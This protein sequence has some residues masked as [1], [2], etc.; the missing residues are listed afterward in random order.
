MSKLKIA[1]IGSGI[2]GLACAWLLSKR[3]KVT[4]FER[5]DRLGGH[6]HT[7]K[8]LSPDG[9]IDVDIGFIVYNEAT[10]QN[11][12][13]L[14]AHLSVNTSR[15]NMSFAV[16]LDKGDYEYSGNGICGLF[17][18]PLNFING[19]HLRLVYDIFRFFRN[20]GALKVNY[21]DTS[22][23]LAQWLNKT[24]YSRDF[25]QR[26]ILPMGAAI[27]SVPSAQIMDFP[28][29]AFA[30]FFQ[31]H[32]LLRIFNR[33]KWR[34][35]TNGCQNYVKKIVANLDCEIRLGLEIQKITRSS[36]SIGVYSNAGV[37]EDFDHCVLAIHANQA[38]QVLSDADPIEHSHLSV[39]KYSDNEAVLHCDHRVM[40]QRKHLWSSWN[41][42]STD[43]SEKPNITYW[44]NNLQPLP[45][46]QNYFVTLNPVQQFLNDSII[47]RYHYS[48]PI[49]NRAAIERQ[50]YL[51]ELQG[52]RRTWF[53]GS[54]FGYGFHEDGLQSGLAVAERLG[55]I[56]RPWKVK[57]QSDRIHLKHSVTPKTISES[58]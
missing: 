4:L 49:F 46:K 9:P 50:K 29:T 57:N 36:D 28:M 31:N 26:H 8:V 55:G 35:V 33:P 2:T 13:A 51:W 27:W 11:L 38:L 48:H 10:Y 18:Q 25:M 39:F 45:T 22:L 17:G 7:V 41:Y 40:P 47:G 5:N 14:F 16:S 23:T 37:I 1:V 3:H 53:A 43:I 15:S 44:M 42:V 54:Y 12:T 34:T 58:F 19:R 52:R 21:L 56:E 30:R 20:V 6:S 32:G 24:G